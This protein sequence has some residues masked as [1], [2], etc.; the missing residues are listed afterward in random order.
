MHGQQIVHHGQ[1]SIWTIVHTWIIVHNLWTIVHDFKI[2][3]KLSI[4][5][6]IVH[7]WTIVHRNA[8]LWA[9]YGQLS[10]DLHWYG[11]S[12]SMDNCPCMDIHKIVHAWISPCTL[13]YA[14]VLA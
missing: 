13:I 11:Q 14:L 2:V 6:T 10:I 1:L 12:I 4:L 8:N 7:A 9:I 3:H 5:W